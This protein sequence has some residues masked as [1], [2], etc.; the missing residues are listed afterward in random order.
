MPGN[1]FL[2]NQLIANNATLTDSLIVQVENLQTNLEILENPSENGCL[3]DF[4]E[5]MGMMDEQFEEQL[6]ILRLGTQWKE[7]K[8]LNGF[9]SNRRR[10]Q[11]LTNNNLLRSLKRSP[12]QISVPDPDKTSCDASCEESDEKFRE[13]LENNFNKKY[14]TTQNSIFDL[15]DVENYEFNSVNTF[16]E[17]PR[18]RK[19]R[20]SNFN[21]TMPSDFAFKS[22][23]MVFVH[24]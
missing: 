22:S 16:K 15:T 6:K 8:V 14:S 9:N 5:V 1:F 20:R 7:L 24:F 17:H 12:V 11:H 10:S 13:L 21:K 23:S 19:H 3:D 18:K 4:D 2:S